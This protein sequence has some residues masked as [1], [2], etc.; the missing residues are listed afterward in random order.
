MNLKEMSFERQVSYLS[1]VMSS[2]K[3]T[4]LGY[5]ALF[6]FR[7]HLA[8]K[9]SPGF[10]RKPVLRWYLGQLAKEYISKYYKEAK[11]NLDNFAQIGLLEASGE[12]ESGMKEYSLNE[13]LYPALQAVLE[14][15]FGKEYIEKVIARAKYMK[16]P[17]I[18]KNRRL[19]EDFSEVKN[20]GR[21]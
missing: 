7:H 9:N 12:E 5:F 15:I 20:E 10:T 14:E 13:N 17:G 18:R 21:S 4:L 1:S 6:A 2:G 19:D 8:C 16:D 3:N 11:A